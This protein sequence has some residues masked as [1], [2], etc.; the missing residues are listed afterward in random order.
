MERTAIFIDAG[1]FKKVLDDFNIKVD[2]LKLSEILAS[3]CN[4]LRTYYYDCP[5]YL[6]SEPTQSERDRKSG[7]DRFITYLVNQP[8][9]EA[10]LGRLQK[11]D[12]VYKQK[13]VD[14]LLSLDLVRLALEHQIQKAIIIAGDSDYVPAIQIAKYA[15]VVVTLCFYER[16][17]DPR[18]QN[19]KGFRIHNELKQACDDWVHINHELIY[20]I[21]L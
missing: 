20:S 9:F 13:M 17:A 11:I 7:F 15:G 10:K 16:N 1:Y 14:V 6:S 21:K 12:N 5:P 19:D 4:R 3:G 8:R 18:R 2:Y